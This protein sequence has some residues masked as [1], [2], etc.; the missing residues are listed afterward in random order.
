[1]LRLLNAILS[2]V[3][4]AGD[5]RADLAH[6]CWGIFN[7]LTDRVLWIEPKYHGPWNTLAITK[8]VAGHEGL[9]KHLYVWSLSDV[10]DIEKQLH[11]CW[12]CLFDYFTLLNSRTTQGLCGLAGDQLLQHLC[13]RPRVAEA[14]AR[15]DRKSKR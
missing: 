2:V 3:E 9:Q 6:G 10:T 1:M 11:E 7:D 12:E 5:A 14:L 13:Q 4:K 8:G 15:H